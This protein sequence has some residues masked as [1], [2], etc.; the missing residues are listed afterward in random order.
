LSCDESAKL[1]PSSTHQLAS[2]SNTKPSTSHMLRIY[3]ST[4]VLSEPHEP[5]NENAL[6]SCGLTHGRNVSW[7]QIHRQQRLYKNLL[8]PHR[9]SISP[10]QLCRLL[11]TNQPTSRHAVISGAETVT[12][13][14][15]QCSKGQEE[16]SRL[17]HRL[18]SMSCSRYKRV[19][20]LCTDR[21]LATKM[22]RIRRLCRLR[23]RSA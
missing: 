14:I 17:D 23:R 5:H 9:R 1:I 8:N 18:G 2:I 6:P 3:N 13:A 19:V 16:G 15:E 12:A 11:R 22:H 21:T 20:A 10:Q 7:V 4:G